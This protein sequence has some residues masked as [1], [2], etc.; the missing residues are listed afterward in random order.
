MNHRN[1]SGK[2]T[3][4]IQMRSTPTSSHELFLSVGRQKN[5]VELGCIGN[6]DLHRK[7]NSEKT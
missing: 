3:R 5:L 1:V 6:K 7:E 2:V 4:C